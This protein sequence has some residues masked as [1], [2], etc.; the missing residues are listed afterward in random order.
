M[1]STREPAQAGWLT[2]SRKDFLAGG[3]FLLMCMGAWLFFRLNHM[4]L[5]LPLH[6]ILKDFTRDLFIFKPQ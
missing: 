4:P 5:N 3:I 6:A 2:E 1:E